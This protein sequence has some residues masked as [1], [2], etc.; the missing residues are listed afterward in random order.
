MAQSRIPSTLPPLPPATGLPWS[1]EV[2]RAHHGLVSAFRTSWG[3]LNLD[4]SD[5]ISL[6]HHLKQAETFMASVV[7]VL[8]IQMDNPLPSEYIETIRGAVTLLV[9]G[10][11][12]AL[13][14]ATLVCVT[15]HTLTGDLSSHH[16]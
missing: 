3:A 15:F 11:Q 13:S 12:I 2:I 5:P 4:E 9:D 1:A 16:A 14:Q 10:L 7:E 8:S 6:G